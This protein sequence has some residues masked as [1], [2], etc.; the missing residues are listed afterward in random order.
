VTAPRSWRMEV[1]WPEAGRQRVYDLAQPLQHGIPH[2]PAHPPFAFT[3]TKKHGEMPY[4]DGVTT[5]S[6]LLTM[7]GHVGTHVDGLAHVAK[8]GRI[9][10]GHDIIDKQSYTEG[11]GTAGID[12][13]PPFLAPGYLVDVP[14]ILGRELTPDDAITA[15]M[16][17]AYF[18][19]TDGPM[20]GSV[21]LVRT[22]WD[23][24]WE[25]NFRYLGGGGA[26]PGVDLGGARWLGERGVIATGSDTIAYE[27]L[28]GP[29]LPVHV[30]LLV[31]KGIHIMEALDLS[32]L[33]AD[34]VREFFFMAAPLRIRGGTGSPI[35]PLA[36][37]AEDAGR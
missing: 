1:R 17:A 26:N 33:A 4:A 8:G 23:A 14:R 11:V 15:E 20:A 13:I 7:G 3:L 27:K 34:G 22:G 35:R 19:A 31:E 10:G 24:F 5:A 37:V 6:E 12:E 30:H 9:F 16:L 2:H 21:V 18:A 28:P 25:D 29:G 36:I 32:E